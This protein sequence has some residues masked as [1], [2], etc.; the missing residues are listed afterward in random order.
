MESVCWP[1]C[2]RR[3]GSLVADG[4]TLGF[5]ARGHIFNQRL[6]CL[7]DAVPLRNKSPLRRALC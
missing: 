7:G 5:Q 1:A 3:I 2:E 4:R 6:P